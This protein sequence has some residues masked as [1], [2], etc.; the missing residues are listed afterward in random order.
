MNKSFG[1]FGKFNCRAVSGTQTSKGLIF[2]S[3]PGG[4]RLIKA[5]AAWI[6]VN[7]NVFR[8]RQVSVMLWFRL[9]QF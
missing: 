1:I 5:L 8:D 4:F 9:R 7:V 2:F 3:A 6:L